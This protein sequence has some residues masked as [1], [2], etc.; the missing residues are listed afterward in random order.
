M[1]NPRLDINRC[2][3]PVGPSNNCKALQFVLTMLAAHM[4]A[5]EDHLLSIS[6]I[7]ANA[8]H[9]LHKGTP[10]EAFIREFLENHLNS[11]VA[12][13][14][15][16]IIDSRS[17]PNVQRNQFD[18]VIYK[19][20]YPRL[21]FGGGINGFL[22]ESVVATIEVKSTLDKAGIEQSVRAARA[23]KNLLRNE[24]KS[25]SSGYVP[26]SILSFV[27]AYDG[28]VNM[29]TVHVWIKETYE[30]MG[31]AEPDM[32]PEQNRSGIV[33]PAL[34]GVFVLGKGFLNF[35]NAPYNFVKSEIRKD[36]P[37]I[38]WAIAQADRG[39]LLSLFLLLTVATS[40]VEGSWL[41]PLPYLET[42]RVSNLQY[43]L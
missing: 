7:P 9:S 36:H 33:G 12:I 39:S 1:H 34:E 21:D 31:I 24:V 16:E 29:Q 20:N 19:R 32:P 28:P 2:P 25:F 17:K 18:I 8:G 40:N 42:F 30:A 14:T 5:V 37:E 38:R 3:D 4:N 6:R 41:N 23:A 10:R 26:P 43:G 15:G 11:T 27:V 22:A 35:D 13:G